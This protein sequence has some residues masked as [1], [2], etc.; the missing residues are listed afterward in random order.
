MEL[1]HVSLSF[2]F[3]LWMPWPSILA[4][5]KGSQNAVLGKQPRAE[6]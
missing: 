3:G 6:A 1:A 4:D 2:L 5:A